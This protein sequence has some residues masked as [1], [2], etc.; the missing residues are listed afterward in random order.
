MLDTF[1][2]SASW[3]HLA[4]FYIVM[5]FMQICAGIYISKETYKYPKN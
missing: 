3:G 2:T 4:I 5:N 1:R